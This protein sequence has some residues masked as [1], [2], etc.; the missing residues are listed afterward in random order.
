[1]R[2]PVLQREE[3]RMTSQEGSM[4]SRLPCRRLPHI[5]HTRMFCGRLEVSWGVDGDTQDQEVAW[6]CPL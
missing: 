5:S 3:T 4:S 6:L 2:L 1:M